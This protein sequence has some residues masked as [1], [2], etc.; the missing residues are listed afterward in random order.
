LGVGGFSIGTGEFVIMGLLPD[1][2]QDLGI[3]IPT[4]GHLISAYALGVV[5]G[6]PVLAVLGARLGRRALLMALM[7]LYAIGNFASAVAPGYSA[8]MLVRLLSGLPH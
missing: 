8:M 1:A 7:V 5:I 3:T 6:A 2:A 4:A